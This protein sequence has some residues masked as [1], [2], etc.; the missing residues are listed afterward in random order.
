MTITNIQVHS[1]LISIYY[2]LSGIEICQ[3]PFYGNIYIFCHIYFNILLIIDHIHSANMFIP[4]IIRVLIIQWMIY[5]LHLENTKQMPVKLSNT[6]VSKITSLPESTD[7]TLIT[8]SYQYMK[9]HSASESQT[10]NR[11]KI[12]M[13][14][15]RFLSP[16]VSFYAQMI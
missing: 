6:T 12:N 14:F 10:N 8:E 2:L 4:L 11:L 16:D 1:L 13:A 3:L 15:A 5:N 7:V 9:N